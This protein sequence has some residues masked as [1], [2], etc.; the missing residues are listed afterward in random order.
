MQQM[1]VKNSISGTAK[2]GLTL[3][4]VVRLCCCQ[5]V[6]EARPES[7]PKATSAPWT[8]CR[9]WE[10]SRGQEDC[11]VRRLTDDLSYLTLPHTNPQKLPTPQSPQKPGFP[12]LQGFETLLSPPLFQY[13]EAGLHLTAAVEVLV[14]SNLIGPAQ[15]TIVEKT[16]YV[17]IIFIV[18][19]YRSITKAFYLRYPC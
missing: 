11:Q 4:R 9:I 5:G 7:S 6:Q 1:D 17:A 10:V 14:F 18:T 15:G 19:A 16:L 12:F 13:Q 2:L 3:G 8:D